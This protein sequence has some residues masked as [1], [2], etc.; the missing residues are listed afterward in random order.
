MR[1]F[2][3]VKVTIILDKTGLTTSVTIDSIAVVAHLI[4]GSLAVSTNSRACICGGGA[5]PTARVPALYRACRRASVAVDE[6]PVIALFKGGKPSA[7]STFWCARGPATC[8]A[9]ACMRR[10][11]LAAG[12]AS[13]TVDSI[14]V[15]A[16]LVARLYAVSTHRR[17]CVSSGRA[18]PTA[19]V[20]ALHRACRRASVAIV[21]VAVITLLFR[22]PFGISTFWCA[23]GP[24]ACAARAR[25]RHLDLAA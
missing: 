22:K 8:A 17:A 5:A 11:D 10:F 20:P 6:V 9:R 15:V 4:S 19:R 25:M 1:R 13:V 24:A 3:R 14:A 21:L 16:C 18:A 23:R 7:F 12:A 2:A